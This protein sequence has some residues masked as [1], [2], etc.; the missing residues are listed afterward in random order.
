MY[1]QL[2]NLRDPVAI[3]NMDSIVVECGLHLVK[4]MFKN[5]KQTSI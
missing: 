4:E 1:K 5:N 3:S 2:Q